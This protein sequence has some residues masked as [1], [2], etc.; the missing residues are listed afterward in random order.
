[1]I[2]PTVEQQA[3]SD[4]E[5]IVAGSKDAINM[6]ESSAAELSET[7]MLEALMFGHTSIR[8]LCY[9]Q[10]EIREKLVKRRWTSN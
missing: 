7:E 2:N 8:E 1:M 10:D 3:Q 4:L 6:V 9:F 5:L